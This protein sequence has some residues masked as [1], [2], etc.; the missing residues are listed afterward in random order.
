VKHSLL[1]I[2]VGV[3]LCGCKT[4]GNDEG[5][6]YLQRSDSITLSAGDAKEVNARTHML[7]AWPPGVGDPRIPMHGQRAAIAAQNYRCNTHGRQQ[8]T[9]GSQAASGPGIGNQQLNLTI[10]QPGSVQGQQA[11][12]K[13]C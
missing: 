3:A 2:C 6:R 5:A 1:F 7:A 9:Q 13:D 11:P 12:P 8:G 10:N 4:Y